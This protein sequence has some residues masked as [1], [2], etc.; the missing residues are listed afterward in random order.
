MRLSLS[1]A[2]AALVVAVAVSATGGCASVLGVH[3]APVSTGTV[4][5]LSPQQADAIATRVLTDVASARTAP[6]SAAKALRTA[7][8]TGSALTVAGATD[9]LGVTSA[10]SP[11]PVNVPPQ[12]RVL[13]ISRGAGWPR[14]ILVQTT[15]ST[16]ASVLNLISSPDV[17]TPF[18]LAASATMHSGATVPALDPLTVGSPLSVDPGSVPVAPEELVSEYAASLAYPKPKPSAH[19]STDDPFSTGVQANAVAQAKAFGALASLSR[20]HKPQ[21]TETVSIALKGGGAL[22]FALLERTD[23]I[24]LASGGKSLTPSPEFQKLVRKKTLTQ[25]AELRTYETVV[26]TV[27]RQ[28]QASVV[29]ADETLVS[30]KGA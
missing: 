23:D 6:A 15:D 29:A 13:A 27:P 26:F 1:K 18:K 14:V 25:N 10:A 19:V 2:G 8:M 12:P 30:A 16:G 28:G 24:T 3:D 5:A 22:V 9:E 7:S 21:P 20:T 4:A 11:N 17:R